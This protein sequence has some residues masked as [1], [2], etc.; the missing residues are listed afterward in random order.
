MDI[1]A[2]IGL[3]APDATL[4]AD[5]GGVA[6]AAL[7]PIDGAERIVR[8]LLNLAGSQVTEPLSNH[9]RAYLT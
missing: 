5:G 7:R 4:V 2:L 9:V 1:D 8:A 6:G 3:L